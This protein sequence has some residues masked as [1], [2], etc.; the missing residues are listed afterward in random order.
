MV[1][2]LIESLAYL[3]DITSK[4]LHIAT[5]GPE[6]TVYHIFLDGFAEVVKALEIHVQVFEMVGLADTLNNINLYALLNESTKEHGFAEQKQSG[7]YRHPTK[8]Q[9]VQSKGQHEIE[10]IKKTCKCPHSY[11]TNIFSAYQPSHASNLASLQ[12]FNQYKIWPKQF[13]QK[14]PLPQL[15]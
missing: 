3:Q 13:H 1:R 7:Q 15:R 10:T 9:Y 2:Y 5:V 4:Y 6:G 11:H 8:K 14:T 12:V